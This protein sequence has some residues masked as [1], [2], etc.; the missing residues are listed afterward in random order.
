MNPTPSL[1]HLDADAALRLSAHSRETLTVA[2][3]LRD[4]NDFTAP[5]LRLLRAADG[6]FHQGVVA[7]VSASF[8][9]RYGLT[10]L[11]WQTFLLSGA[12]DRLDA[13]HSP[14]PTLTTAPT[15]A[16]DA[17]DAPAPTA[18]A[19]EVPSIH[20]ADPVPTDVVPTA[21]APSSDTPA[22]DLTP[23]APPELPVNTPAEEGAP[24]YSTIDPDGTLLPL[25]RAAGAM[26]A[27]FPD[28]MPA[29]AQRLTDEG[30][31]VTTGPLYV[32]RS[33]RLARLRNGRTWN[34]AV[35]P[36]RIQDLHDALERITRASAPATDAPAADTAAAD[37]DAPPADQDAPPADQ[38]AAPAPTP[39]LLPLYEQAR[40][41]L[42]EETAAGV[43]M[44][45]LAAALT[46]EGVKFSDGRLYVLRQ[47]RYTTDDGSN[48]IGETKLRELLRVLG[49]RQRAREQDAPP[50]TDDPQQGTLTDEEWQRLQEIRSLV[51]QLSERYTQDALVTRLKVTHGVA[52]STPTLSLFRRGQYGVGYT[53]PLRPDRQDALL[54]GLR[55]M[56]AQQPGAA[57]ATIAPPVPAPA[58]PTLDTPV[59]PLASV[60]TMPSLKLP[61]RSREARDF[62]VPLNPGRPEF[63]ADQ[64]RTVLVMATTGEVHAHEVAKALGLRN[65]EAQERLSN[66]PEL[67][68]H[69]KGRYTLNTTHEP[70]EATA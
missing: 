10:D 58:T 22:P 49:D 45:A 63:T 17:P 33:G 61:A 40:T 18:P 12:A 24:P 53:R 47:G 20:S 52:V 13:A 56:A 65:A 50:L 19:P 9:Q 67:D 5:A 8:T 37:Q 15:V 14:A 41:L 4:W 38:G 16:T 3:A 30:V 70:Q 68:A 55:A 23:P 31:S 11:F 1:A 54:G 39:N 42:D 21:P 69:G 51:L 64:R 27:Q 59:D 25:Y 6:P 32:L 43:T 29:L 66:M 46:A 35:S 36:H 26:V 44:R 48:L 34:W 7:Q 57:A 28:G 62:Q 2:L 60:P